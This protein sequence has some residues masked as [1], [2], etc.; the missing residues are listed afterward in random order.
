MSDPQLVDDTTHAVQ[1]APGWIWDQLVDEVDGTRHGAAKEGLTVSLGFSGTGIAVVGTLGSS[2]TNGQPRTSYAID[3]SVVSTYNAPNTPSGQ[4]HYNVTFFSTRNLSPGDHEI[5]I[6]NLDGTNPNHYWLDYF[7]IYKS[8]P[9][10]SDPV[11]SSQPPSPPPSSMTTTSHSFSSTF[12]SN[13]PQMPSPSSTV[14]TTSS[15][16]SPS[17]PASASASNS[18]SASDSTSK[19]S[20]TT[21]SGSNTSSASSTLP[22]SLQDTIDPLPFQVSQTSGSVSVSSTANSTTP[23]ATVEA[24]ASQ[25]GKGH[26]NVGAI[27]GGVAGGIAL[28]LLLAFIFLWRRRIRRARED[29][30]P[31]GSTLPQTHDGFSPLPPRRNGH[32]VKSQ[33]MY[34]NQMAFASMQPPAGSVAGSSYITSLSFPADPA[35]EHAQYAGPDLATGAGHDTPNQHFTSPGADPFATTKAQDSTVYESSSPPSSSASSTTRLVP[36][37]RQPT[38]PLSDAASPVTP[39]GSATSLLLHTEVART[40][41]YSPPQAQSRAQ[42]LLRASS[43]RNG[44]GS[45]SARSVVQDVD[46][47]LRTYN[48]A[49]LPPPYT[50]E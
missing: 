50:P 23:L 45:S 31:F 49:A 24:N 9:A 16:S 6:T 33:E 32:P 37:R 1:Y 43:S 38:S 20:L 22:T 18:A 29:I 15:S 46:S 35:L 5:V 42:S 41:W 4:T 8:P 28:I 40:P 19:S 47:G 25:P 12:T 13:P 2:D 39:A 17:L 48:E 7:L 3:G 30:E 27:A 34:F 36:S 11:P 10:N 26:T 21:I 14:T 44:R